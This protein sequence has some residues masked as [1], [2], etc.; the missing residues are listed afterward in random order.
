MDRGRLPRPRR[1]GTAHHVTQGRRRQRG[2]RFW[3]RAD[4][5]RA[6]G[7]APAGDAPH[8]ARRQGR[9]RGDRLLQMHGRAGDAERPTAQPAR[10][11][12]GRRAGLPQLEGRAQAG[13]RSRRAS[14]LAAGAQG[15]GRYGTCHPH[16]LRSP[17]GRRAGVDAR[18]PRRR[19]GRRY[20]D[21]RRRGGGRGRTYG[22]HPSRNLDAAA[23]DGAAQ[24]PRGGRRLR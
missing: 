23:G 9:R 7:L 13:S 2:A 19:R 22:A 3:L 17:Q 12:V 6:V 18:E 14:C 1:R 24:R 8:G 20:R 10:A 4:H 16:R 21:R 11:I 15:P 5:R